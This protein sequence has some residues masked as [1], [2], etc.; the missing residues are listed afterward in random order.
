MDQSDGFRPVETFS[1][2]VNRAERTQQVR[3]LV[4]LLARPDGRAW[5]LERLE[6][7]CGHDEA[8]AAEVFH[9][10]FPL[11]DIFTAD[12]YHCRG[13]SH[14]E[15][16]FIAYHNDLFGLPSDFGVEEVWRTAPRGKIRHP[17]AG[18]RAGW[19]EEFLEERI[20]NRDLHRRARDAR[21]MLGTEA[22]VFLLTA[23]DIVIVECK[24]R[25]QLSIEQYQRQRMAGETLARRLGRGFHFGIVCE[26]QRDPEFAKIREPYVTWGEIEDR[27]TEM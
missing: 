2:T 18:G 1:W 11:R 19:Y 23:S 3:L 13:T 7:R 8:L 9:L 14:L 25:S 24:Y 17:A 20:P 10:C 4:P 16:E 22:D 6:C 27:L 21:R 15:D 12:Y 5:F 26:D